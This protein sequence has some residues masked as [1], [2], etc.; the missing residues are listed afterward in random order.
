MHASSLNSKVSMTLEHAI[1]VCLCAIVE[2]LATAWHAALVFV[3]VSIVTVHLFFVQAHVSVHMLSSLP[4]LV[5]FSNDS[6]SLP[7]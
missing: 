6:Q 5:Q 4:Q 7:E 1:H 3:H 2:Q